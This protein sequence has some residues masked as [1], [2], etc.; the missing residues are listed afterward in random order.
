[1]AMMAHVKEL[2]TK[3]AAI[4]SKIKAEQKTPLPD[5][6]R[7]ASLKKRKLFLKEQIQAHLDI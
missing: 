1:M 3:H 4:D 7:I 2:E 6:L 5:S